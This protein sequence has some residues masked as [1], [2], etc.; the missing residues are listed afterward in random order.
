LAGSREQYG[1]M[2]VGAGSVVTKSL[3]SFVLAA[4]NPCRVIRELE[5]R[6]VVLPA[7]GGPA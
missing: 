4:G 5:P 6:E 2:T 1:K 3:P 7:P